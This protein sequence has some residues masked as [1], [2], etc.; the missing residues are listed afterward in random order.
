MGHV[1]VYN[2]RK[3]QITAILAYANDNDCKVTLSLLPL[4]TFEK[5]DGSLVNI[6]V[7]ELV[8]DYKRSFE[9]I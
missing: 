5:R 4:V 6:D 7:D 8:D 3:I 2:L 9:R 1:K